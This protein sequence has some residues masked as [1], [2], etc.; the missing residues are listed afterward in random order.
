MGAPPADWR[1]EVSETEIGPGWACAAP[2]V[3]GE[4]TKEEADKFRLEGTAPGDQAPTTSAAPAPAGKPAPSAAPAPAGLPAPTAG[5]APPPVGKPAP[6]SPNGAGS[7]AGGATGSGGVATP[8][9]PPPPAP[10]KGFSVALFPV[11][12]GHRA[13]W[14]LWNVT[15]RSDG[16]VENLYGSWAAFERAGDYKLRT[17]DAALKDLTSGPHPLPA[18]ANG[19]IAE[20][21][22]AIGVAPASPE[23]T[24]VPSAGQ[25]GGPG[26]G[27]TAMPAPSAGQTGA[28]GTG[29]AGGATAASGVAVP[30][31]ATVDCPPVAVPLAPEKATSSF[32]P[33]CAPPAPQVVTITGVEL[34]LMQ[35][36]AFEDGH[37][38]LLLVPAY[39][40]LG[41]FDNGSAWETSVIALHPDAI[42]PPPIVPIA[43]DGRESG[44][45]GVAGKAV[46]PTPPDAP[47][48]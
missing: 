24:P 2:A 39:R 25:S 46:P 44:G 17:V 18:V 30:A 34:G 14:A 27:A 32:M 6:D 41:H 19:A 5:I 29:V 10:V 16:R 47:A 37:V 45:T 31:I 3:P 8:A 13:E 38:R 28:A 4:L 23:A 48:R 11:L 43:V 15:L 26:T 35:A 9:C 12:D 1:A 22:P 42:A 7:T 36:P 40:F 20:N 33:A 21:V